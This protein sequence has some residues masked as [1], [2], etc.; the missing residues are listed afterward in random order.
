MS[1]TIRPIS[2]R[3]P[4]SRALWDDANLPMCAVL[5]PHG[6]GVGSDGSD[7]LKLCHLLRCLKCGAPHPTLDT[8]SLLEEHKR[9]FCYLCGDHSSSQ[10]E[11]QKKVRVNDNMEEVKDDDWPFTNYHNNS[12]NGSSN[13][14]KDIVVQLP[15]FNGKDLFS[16]SAKACP[17]VWWIVLDATMP[18]SSPYW[19]TVTECLQR[20]LMP[21]EDL[22]EDLS[23]PE[24]AHVGLI[25]A[26]HDTISTWEL[27]S[28]V[29]K[30]CHFPLAAATGTANDQTQDNKNNYSSE[31]IAVDLSLT[32]VDPLHQPCIQAALR[33]VGDNPSSTGQS[34]NQLQ[35]MALGATIE[36]ILEFMEQAKHPGDA[37]SQQEEEEE[38]NNTNTPLRYAGGKIT[39]LLGRP[40]LE[41]KRFPVQPQPSFGAGGVGGA[42]HDP[43]ESGKFTNPVEDSSDLTPSKLAEYCEPLKPTEDVFDIIGTRCAH[44]AFGVDIII[45]EAKSETKEENGEP[46]SNESPTSSRARRR[47]KV[48]FLRPF[49]GIPLLRVLADTSGAPGPIMVGNVNDLTNQVWARTPWQHGMAFAT[50]IR[51]RTSPGWS[52]EGTPIEPLNKATHH[53]ALFLTSGGMAGPAVATND[54]F[55]ILGTCDSHTSVT[56]DLQVTHPRK[57]VNVEHKLLGIRRIVGAKFTLK[58]VIQT[59]IAYTCI[60]QDKGGKARVVRKMRISCCPMP[61]ATNVESIYNALDPEALATA[62]FQKLALNLYEEGLESTQQVGIDWLKALLVCVYRSA[63]QKLKNES[64][65]TIGMAH[66][67]EEDE[68]LPFDSS[69]R[70]LM[71]NSKQVMTISPRNK[72][73]NEKRKEL[74][75]DD[76]L[77]GLGHDRIAALPLVVFSLLQSDALRPSPNVSV[78]A[79]CAA[80]AQMASMTPRDLVKC[81]AP[82]LSLWSSKRDAPIARSVDLSLIESIKAYKKAGAERNDD[83]VFVMDSPQQV[84]VYK[85]VLKQ[86][87]KKFKMSLKPYEPKTPK[88]EAMVDTM[89]ASYRTEPF[90]TTGDQSENASYRRFLHSMIE[91]LPTARHLDGDGNSNFK[92]W[93]A[94]MAQ[95]VQA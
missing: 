2:R 72:K 27:S 10:L 90:C 69:Y 38:N 39:C 8:H 46:K 50:E 70:L 82:S 42:I 86:E 16:E 87:T 43:L 3:F 40:P 34:N 35:G 60:E 68:T 24:Y 88:L 28:P 17:P 57:K 37:L 26:S 79:R 94:D 15:L 51:V 85:A 45:V 55:F 29:P 1:S 76:V 30:V 95:S 48:E 75:V 71:S 74:E 5:T 91:D 25:L 4:E 13:S 84:L 20:I 58:P 67:D 77:L 49:Y 54:N 32:P 36:T 65:K 33:A 31:R 44:A 56:L 52:V 18:Q 47:N 7:G 12:K 21:E 9:L 80:I 66:D 73:S 41:I 83:L 64:C 11:E 62:L 14:N 92:D 81:I 22:K 53:L 19:K 93:K 89:I 23:P 6:G 59:C 78:D 61:M 63:L